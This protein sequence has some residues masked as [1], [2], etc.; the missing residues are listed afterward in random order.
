[1]QDT[2]QSVS[3][4]ETFPWLGER[5]SADFPAYNCPPEHLI[6]LMRELSSRFGYEKL[7]DLTAAD[8]GVG[9]S[10]R[11]TC[12]YHLY[13]HKD[14]AYVRIA[15][16]CTGDAEPEIPSVTGIW[17][18]AD[19]LEREV[20]DMFGI[21]F[22][23][24][25]DMRRIL[26]WDNYPYHPLRKDFPLAGLEA[27]LPSEDPAVA[28]EIIG[29]RTMT[30]PECGGPFT[31]GNGTLSSKTEPSAKDQSWNEKKLRP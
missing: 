14:H 3:L 28:A 23:G 17:G 11:F 9:A 24:H 8:W 4:T 29:G 19:W 18:A 21:T 20:Y 27:P 15:S 10:P 25:P 5:P 6:E 1:M 22:T 31:A 13:S 2:T 16:D 30:A 7:S 12:F 26:M